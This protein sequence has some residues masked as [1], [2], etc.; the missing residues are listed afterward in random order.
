MPLARF[1]FKLASSPRLLRIRFAFFTKGCRLAFACAFDSFAPCLPRLAI[2][3][4][5]SDSGRV[6]FDRHRGKTARSSPTAVS[7]PVNKYHWAMEPSPRYRAELVVRYKRSEDS[8][9]VA[10]QAAWSDAE[11]AIRKEAD[12][13][14]DRLLVTAIERVQIAFGMH[15]T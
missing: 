14:C 5:G 6:A 9:N 8:G 7:D 15:A 10:D 4:I 11:G 1:R 13:F 12:R 2:W 3:A